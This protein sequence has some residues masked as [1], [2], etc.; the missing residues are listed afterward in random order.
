VYSVC[1]FAPQETGERIDAFLRDHPEFSRRVAEPRY[2]QWR[3]ET[4]DLRFPPGIERR[5][6]FFIALLER[7]AAT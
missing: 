1:S 4:G 3:L 5:D 2:A 7:R 6:G